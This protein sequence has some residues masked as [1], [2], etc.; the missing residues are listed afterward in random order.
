VAAAIAMIAM[1]AFLLLYE[2]PTTDKGS[3]VAEAPGKISR[4]TNPEKTPRK[5]ALNDGSFVILQAGS[6]LRFPEIF[7]DKREV[8]LTGEAFFEVARDTTRPFLVYSDEIV[9]KVLGTSFSIKAYAEEDEIVVAVKT[10][11]VSVFTQDDHEKPVKQIRQ[12]V[13]LTPNQQAVYDRKADRVVKKLADNPQIIEQHPSLKMHYTN[14]PV[15]EI[16][17]AIEKSYGVEIQFNQEVLAGCTLT[18]DMAE[19]GLYERIAI[20]CHALGAQYKVQETSIVIETQ[21]GCY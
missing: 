5:V 8:Y 17:E 11:K 12:E 4:L 2:V 10:G 20:I 14:T 15:V 3:P 13:I 1:S 16:F 6:E 18:T 21:G 9:T 19:E 7:D